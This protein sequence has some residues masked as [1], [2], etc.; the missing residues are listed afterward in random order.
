MNEYSSVN[1][2]DKVV[3][4]TGGILKTASRRRTLLTIAAAVF[5]LAGASAF[6]AYFLTRPKDSNSGNTM[7]PNVL[8]TTT[9]PITSTTT[10]S[11]TSTPTVSPPVIARGQLIGYYGNDEINEF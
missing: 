11:T 10:T 1:V 4:P 6:T 5:V 8:P 9:V 3:S 2:Q 7:L